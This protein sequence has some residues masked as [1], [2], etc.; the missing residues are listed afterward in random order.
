MKEK[1]E[2]LDF[3]A[4]AL[5]AVIMFASNFLNTE[6][7]D[8]GNNNFAVWFVISFLSFGCG[9]YINKSL[10]WQFGGK[11]VFSI[12]IAVTFISVFMI[13]FFRDFFG[14]NYLLAENFILYSLRNI[15][16]GAMALFGMSIVETMI[17]HNKNELLQEKLNN[18]QPPHSDYDSKKESDLDIREAKLH[19][20]KI[21][22]EAELEAKNIILKKER[23]QQEL[24]E[25]IRAE[26]E[27]IKKY[28]DVQ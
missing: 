27:L 9:W 15:T 8:Y 2:L 4:P 19:A 6:I 13:T 24:R 20:Q 17:Q 11:V 14:A 25:F 22:T 12:V 10:G 18:N 7:F 1:R 23:I 5:L 26:K 28:E 16:L 3:V 21:I